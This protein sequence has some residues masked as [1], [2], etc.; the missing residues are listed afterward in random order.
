MESTGSTE[1]KRTRGEK[2]EGLLQDVVKMAR[3]NA[4]GLRDL[5]Q[6]PVVS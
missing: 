4:L 2:I 6:Y 3:E 1:R 5:R